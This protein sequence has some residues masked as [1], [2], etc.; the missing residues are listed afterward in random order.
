MV[1]YDDANDVKC[2]NNAYCVRCCWWYK[3]CAW[4]HAPIVPNVSNWFFFYSFVYSKR[5]ICSCDLNDKMKLEKRISRTIDNSLCIKRNRE[6]KD[7]GFSLNH[8]FFWQV[9]DYGTVN[10]IWETYLAISLK[11][12]YE[13]RICVE[14]M[15]MW[16]G[17]N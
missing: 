10:A 11:F 17:V 3:H 1:F 7:G 14:N 9:S 16:D 8:F 13:W 15:W 12:K 4:T 6:W 2:T 5:A